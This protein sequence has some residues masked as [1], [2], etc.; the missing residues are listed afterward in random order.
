LRVAV[1]IAPAKLKL[2]RILARFAPWMT[3]KGDRREG[4]LTRDPEILSEQHADTLRHNRISPPLF[5]G[6]VEGGE[7]LLARAAEIRVPI[8][9][10]VG[11][12]DT[13]I[14]PATTRAFYERLGSEDKTLL[15]YPKMLHEPFNDLGRAQV[16]DDLA[17]WLS[18]RLPG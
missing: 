15:I 6:M 3:L 16:F 5:F 2:G 9:V 18:A 4:V 14:D 7:Q 13:V 11:G 10:L 1:P 17:R 8:L 12:Q